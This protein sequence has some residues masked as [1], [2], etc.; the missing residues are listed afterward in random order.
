MVLYKQED[1]QKM[2][3]EISGHDLFFDVIQ[4][5][6]KL[7]PIVD[8]VVCVL[9]HDLITK[10]C[11]VVSINHDDCFKFDLR[12]VLNDL[13]KMLTKKWVF[14]KKRI[15]HL[16]KSKNWLDYN[17]Y[18]FQKNNMCISLDEY[19]TNA[20]AFFKTKQVNNHPTNKLIP[21]VKH[22]EK[23]ENIC[24]ELHDLNEFVADK[25]F[26]VVNNAIT[27]TL[28]DIEKNGLKVDVDIFESFFKDKNAK[29]NNGYVYT[30]YNLY[31]ST[32]RPSNKFDHINYSALQKENGCR[33]SF[34]SRHGDDGMLFMIDYSAYHP[35]IVAKLINYD[36]PSNVY[37]YLGKYY[38]NKQSLTLEEIKFS[39]N[40]TFQCM[41]GNVPDE[42]KD[43]PFFKKM[44][45]Y[46]NHRWEFFNKNGYVETPVA[47]RCFK[48]SNIDSP[49]PNKL[50]NYIL[51]SSEIEFGIQ[52]LFNINNYL[53][54]KHSKAILYT[55]DSVL[56]DVHKE[57][58]KE[59]LLTLKKLMENN[60]F[61]VK[62]Y[63]GKNYHS[64]TIINL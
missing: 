8:E 13:D 43:I 14:D 38:L 20:H 18:S 12:V 23:F 62:C 49:N 32:G 36:L 41:Y 39:K 46:I 48:Q 4:S 2:V 44:N 47:N 21:I 5:N 60:M 16:L 42:Y 25:S 57:D 1:Y 64:M 3:H 27:E 63:A 9:I 15:I 19:D 58:K 35:H 55:Y 56:F 40:L 17:I 11:F 22:L 59:T 29:V 7:H 50:F 6:D 53:K 24:G 45:E 10:K 37:E 31:T 33:K 61:P 28:A 26:H 51:Q 30:Q 52:S 54:N 34:I